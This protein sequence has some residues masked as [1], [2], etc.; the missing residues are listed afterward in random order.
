MK[1]SRHETKFFKDAKIT[2]D[3]L[4]AENDKS[5]L[6]WLLN[7]KAQLAIV[8][9]FGIIGAGFLYTEQPGFG[10]AFIGIVVILTSVFFVFR[11]L[12][13]VVKWVI[14]LIEL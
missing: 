9:L 5:P 14:N 10:W 13:P 12:W 4:R 7:A 8:L 2:R 1:T 6:A 11:V 3:Y